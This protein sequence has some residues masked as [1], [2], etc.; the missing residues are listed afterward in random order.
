MKVW[1]R[2][3]RH[4]RPAGISGTELNYRGRASAP[5]LEDTST[6]PGAGMEWAVSRNGGR[7]ETEG[8]KIMKIGPLKIN[9]LR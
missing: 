7:S 9:E 2:H 3:T 4:L 1:D 5:R 8:R 6:E